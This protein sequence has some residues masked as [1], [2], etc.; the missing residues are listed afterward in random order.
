M[1]RLRDIELI[2]EPAE[3][4]KI[5]KFVMVKDWVISQ[6]SVKLFIDDMPVCEIHPFINREDVRN[7]HPNIKI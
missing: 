5:G 4:E 6:G 1:I 7:S 3:F 2:D